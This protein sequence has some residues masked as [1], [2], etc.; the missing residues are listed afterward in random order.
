MPLSRDGL[1]GA[2]AL[3][4]LADIYVICGEQD[5]AISLLE[6]LLTVPG[7]TSVNLLRLDPIY[8]PLRENPRFQTLVEQHDKP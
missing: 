3:M 5:E 8:D 4:D 2:D 7:W 6:K 1:L